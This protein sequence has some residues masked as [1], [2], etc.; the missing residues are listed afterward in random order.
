MCVAAP[1]QEDCSGLTKRLYQAVKAAAKKI[2][3]KEHQL[4]HCQG[5]YTQVVMGASH[6]NRTKVAINYNIN[7]DT[8]GKHEQVIA[9]LLHHDDIKQLAQFRSGMFVSI[10]TKP[11]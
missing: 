3:L 8:K 1:T 5:N 4:H 10:F 11:C 6:G 7:E 9:A 2:Q